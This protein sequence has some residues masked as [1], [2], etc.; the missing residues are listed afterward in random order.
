MS[1]VNLAE[2]YARYLRHDSSLDRLIELVGRYAIAV[3][4]FDAADAE[5]A[6]RLHRATRANGLSLG[7]CICLAL[8]TRRGLTAVTADRVWSEIA[9]LDVRVRVIR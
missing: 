5:L 7:D 2:V 1:S 9:G 8:A 3:V 4:P 6:G